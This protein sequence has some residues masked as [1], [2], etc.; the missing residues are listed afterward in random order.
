MIAR[1]L[2]AES[3]YCGLC[4]EKVWGMQQYE[5]HFLKHHPFCPFPK[6]ELTFGWVV[7]SPGKL[8]IELN[9]VRN[10]FALNWDVFMSDLAFEMGFTTERA[11]QYAKSGADHHIA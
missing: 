1:T 3:F 5:R 7:L 10:F 4:T 8:H 6:P 11:Q 2:I 9:M